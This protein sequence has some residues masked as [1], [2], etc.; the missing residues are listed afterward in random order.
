MKLFTFLFAGCFIVFV[1]LSTAQADTTIV[2]ETF[3]SYVDGGGLPDQAAF[4]AN[5]RPDNGD[6]I[7]DFLDPTNAGF[8]V[9]DQFGIV[10]PPND[11]PPGLQ[12]VGVANIGT[13]INESN[14][15][16][17]LMPSATQWIRYGG[18]I[19][20]DGPITNDSASGMR[21]AIGLRNDNYDRDPVTFGCQCGT[22]FLELGFYNTKRSRSNHWRNA[23]QHSV[24]I[25]HRFVL[26]GSA[27]QCRAAQLA[28]VQVGS[29]V[30]YERRSSRRRLQQQR[31]GGC[32]GL[33]HVAR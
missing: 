29:G 24:S 21:Q 11:N 5:W 1:G 4:E 18:D 23:P 16:F 25:S 28:L 26:A 20:N 8:L 33:C 10:N 7:P 32:R 27:R 31:H 2:N 13:G 3:D 9:P 19:Y 17:S 12:G 22:N 15:T 30:G 14:A 6:G